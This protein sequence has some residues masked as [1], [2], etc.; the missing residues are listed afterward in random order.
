MTFI[1]VRIKEEPELVVGDELR[2]SRDGVEYKFS[3]IF[4]RLSLNSLRDNQI[5][6]FSRQ[7]IVEWFGYRLSI[8]RHAFRC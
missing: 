4:N 8:K 7:L 6:I 1:V 5:A 3:F 2:G